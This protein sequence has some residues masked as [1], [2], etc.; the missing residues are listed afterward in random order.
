[1]AILAGI[2]E[3]GFGPILG[4]LVVSSSV[5]RVPDNLVWGDLWGILRRSISE[6]R[7]GLAGRLLIADSKKAF[8]RSIGIRHL[9][10]NGFGRAQTFRQRAPASRGAF[11]G[12]VSGLS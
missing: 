7:T 4:P 2:D 8:S 10:A 6:K 5:F 1:M 9:A 11:V 12:A 3:A